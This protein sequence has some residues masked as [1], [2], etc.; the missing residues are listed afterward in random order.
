MTLLFMWRRRFEVRRLH[1]GYEDGRGSD[2][3]REWNHILSGDWIV[4]RRRQ[5]RLWC[6]WF[7]AQ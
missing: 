3:P 1:V 6:G 4:L 5:N 2:L 7:V